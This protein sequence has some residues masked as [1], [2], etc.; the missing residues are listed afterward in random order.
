MAEGISAGLTRAPAA[1]GRR[2]GFTVGT[3]FFV[4]AAIAM[5][6]GKT[7]PATVLAA[8]G[9]LLVLGAAT[10]P[11]QLVPVERVWMKMALVISKVTTPIFMGIVWFLVVTPTGMIRRALGKSQIH[12]DKGAATFWAS[13]PTG[14]RAGNLER[15]F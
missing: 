4:L 9:A 6:R 15:Q 14:S 13:R 10:I 1:Q 8:L 3:A 7:T 2:F 12:R 11:A 5:W